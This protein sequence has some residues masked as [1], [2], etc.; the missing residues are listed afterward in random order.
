MRVTIISVCYNSSK[1]IE[2][3]ILSVANQLYKNIEYI[4]IDGSSTDGTLEIIKKHQDKITIWISERDR[5]LYHAMNKG[6]ELATGELVGIL[7]CDDVLFSDKTISNIVEFHQKNFVEA[8][9]GNVVQVDDFGK[10]VRF[11]SSKFWNPNKLK[12]GLMPPHPAIFFHKDL[13]YKY[14]KYDMDLKIGADFELVIRYFLVN[15]IVWKYSEIT[16]TAMLIGGLS[17]SGFSSY[18]LVTKE[19][20]SALSKNNVAHSIWKLRIRFFWK[21]NEFCSFDFIKLNKN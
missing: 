16:T 4:I 14:G 18:N 19:I 2:R 7:N 5:G 11:I 12:I 3:T 17:T 9:V 8:S 21:L 15:K 20:D 1:T 10:E 6:I 13:F